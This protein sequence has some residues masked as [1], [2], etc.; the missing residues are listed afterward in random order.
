MTKNSP[1]VKRIY[2]RYE[3]LAEQYASKLFGYDSLGIGL[4]RQDIVQECK[5]KIY[6]SIISYIKKWSE[7]KKTGRY[8]PVPILFYLQLCLNNKIKD[9]IKQMNK[10]SDRNSEK[11]LSYI[12]IQDCSFDVGI[13]YN[14]DNDI[15]FQKLKVVINGVD[16][17]QGLNTKQKISYLLYLKGY[18][19]QEINKIFKK[20]PVNV[21]ETI[22]KQNKLLR[23]QKDEILDFDNSRKFQYQFSE[24]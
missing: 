8:K 13:E 6:T 10:G 16:L 23:S 2:L 12:S 21:E 15:D 20:L 4:E 22:N 14:M 19:I 1:T 3:F 5:I 18:R 11:S 9:L 17:F 7:Y 24:D